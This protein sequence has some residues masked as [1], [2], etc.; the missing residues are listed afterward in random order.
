MAINFDR[1]AWCTSLIL[2]AEQ[3]QPKV[4]WAAQGLML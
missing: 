3:V 4:C 1:C 2:N